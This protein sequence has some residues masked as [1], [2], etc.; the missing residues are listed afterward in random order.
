MSAP[1]NSVAS[2][3]RDWNNTVTTPIMS[4]SYAQVA[5]Q[6][7]FPTKEQAIVTDAVEGVSIKD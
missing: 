5:Q 4:F 3:Q 1:K 7:N 6:V 2:S